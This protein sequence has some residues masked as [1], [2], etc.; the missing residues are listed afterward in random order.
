[1]GKRRSSR[2]LWN[3]SMHMASVFILCKEK[4]MDSYYEEMAYSK[5]SENILLRKISGLTKDEV[6]G[7]FRISGPIPR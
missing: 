7:K 2:Q 5:M 3:I 1:M 6:S 4:T